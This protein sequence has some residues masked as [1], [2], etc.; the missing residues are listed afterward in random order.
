MLRDLIPGAKKKRAEEN[1]ALEKVLREARSTLV[2]STLELPQEGSN[3]GEITG[4]VFFSTGMFLTPLGSVRLGV[5]GGYLYVVPQGGKIPPDSLPQ[6][7]LALT[8]V[9]QKT[10][11]QTNGSETSSKLTADIAVTAKLSPEMQS[12]TSVEDTGKTSGSWS[13]GIGYSSTHT[14]INATPY[15]MGAKFELSSPQN[16]TEPLRVCTPDGLFR[17]VPEGT[18]NASITV[19][20]QPWSI[21]LL[22]GTD[23]WAL[24][25]EEKK[26]K[27]LSILLT[28]LVADGP[29]ELTSP[30]PVAGGVG[31]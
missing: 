29:W 6:T 19:T 24:D 9:L 26:K 21:K 27:L 10:Q 28:K 22:G 31:S 12:K 15:G 13:Q 20:F 2:V 5:T 23:L 11:T 16:G 14:N 25:Q 30:V 1:K 18:G 3:S 8:T 7:P 17:V 4:N